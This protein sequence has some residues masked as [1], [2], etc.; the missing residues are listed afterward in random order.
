M[1]KSN[2]FCLETVTDISYIGKQFLF[3]TNKV[4]QVVQ[5]LIPI[6][7]IIFFTY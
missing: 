4:V 3:W 7:S 6:A 5:V 1:L 2:R